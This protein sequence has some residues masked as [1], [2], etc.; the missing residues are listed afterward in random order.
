VIP[1]GIRAWLQPNRELIEFRASVSVKRPEQELISCLQTRIQVI[2][3]MQ[4]AI[5]QRTAVGFDLAKSKR[6][7]RAAVLVGDLHNGTDTLVLP[8]RL[9]FAGIELIKA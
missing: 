9:P 4:P 1:A 3:E 2:N 5:L 8:S 7:K 6:V